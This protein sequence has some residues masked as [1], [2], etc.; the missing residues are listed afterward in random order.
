MEIV[1]LMT[2]V[3]V[4][5]P[6]ISGIFAKFPSRTQIKKKTIVHGHLVFTNQKI[7]KYFKIIKK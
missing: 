6:K 7:L 5:N 2:K 1:I 3:Q 4:L